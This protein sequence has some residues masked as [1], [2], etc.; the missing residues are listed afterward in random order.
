[1]WNGPVSARF[2]EYS[3]IPGLR[4]GDRSA[5]LGSPVKLSKAYGQ[6]EPADGP[7]PG[8]LV[9]RHTAARGQPQRHLLLSALPLHRQAG[10][11][12]SEHR[13]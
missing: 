6:D 7:W 8:G 2:C 12:A 9:P 5:L 13:S 11:A 10:A 3:L 4:A 1:M